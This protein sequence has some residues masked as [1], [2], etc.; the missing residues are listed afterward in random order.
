MGK[1]LELD[2]KR[3][4][5]VSDYNSEG[6]RKINWNVDGVIKY[7]R[8][9]STLVNTFIQNNFFIQETRES[10]ADEQAIKLVEKYKYQKDRPYFIFFKLIK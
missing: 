9:F 2:D 1:Y 5:Y 7:H 10:I 8:T 3:Y 4:Y 6:V